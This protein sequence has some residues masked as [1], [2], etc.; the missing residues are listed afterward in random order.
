M[1][2]SLK[3]SSVLSLRVPDSLLSY[4]SE[5]RINSLGGMALKHNEDVLDSIVCMYIGALYQSGYNQA[6]FG[7]AL[8]GYI[9]VPTKRC[10]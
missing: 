8:D 9:F 4:M 5:S 7:T 2:R 1:I 6:V 10:T 3:D